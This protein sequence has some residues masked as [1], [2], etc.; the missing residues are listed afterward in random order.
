MYLLPGAVI[1]KLEGDVFFPV[2]AKGVNLSEYEDLVLEALVFLNNWN[3]RSYPTLVPYASIEQIGEKNYKLLEEKHVQIIVPITPD[4]T[5]KYLITCISCDDQNVIDE[6]DK[7][8]LMALSNTLH[9][10]IQ[11]SSTKENLM[12]SN[13]KLILLQKSGILPRKLF[14]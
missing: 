2:R 7:L 11:F 12:Q 5:L 4:K 13:L 8:T 10:A 6:Q 14:C 9:N 1:L 3:L